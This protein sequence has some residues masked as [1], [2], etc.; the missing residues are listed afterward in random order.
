MLALVALVGSTVGWAAQ[1]PQPVTLDP[2]QTLANSAV[3]DGLIA[4]ALPLIAKAG[5]NL[6]EFNVEK[7]VAGPEGKALFLPVQATV[8]L[9][10]LP[11]FIGL[12]YVHEL[13]Q[14]HGQVIRK[15]LYP[16]RVSRLNSA[17]SPLE[18]SSGNVRGIIAVPQSV[19]VKAK[20]C[21]AQVTK[22]DFSAG[23]V[24][25]SGSITFGGGS[26]HHKTKPKPCKSWKCSILRNL[27]LFII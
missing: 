6:Q 27:P 12:L 10:K 15:G 17:Q 26:S 8:N 21:L 3:R 22:G 9:E 1:V 11:A 23:F 13:L 18:L 20:L 25:L 7:A 19:T 4:E 14:V 5:Y 2:G 24:C 16:V